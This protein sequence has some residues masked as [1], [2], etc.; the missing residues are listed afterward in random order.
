MITVEHLLCSNAR[1]HVALGEG[2]ALLPQ[3]CLTACLGMLWGSTG[4]DHSITQACAFTYAC[5]VGS[6]SPS[7]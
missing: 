2:H 4:N 7:D 5:P 1:G 3:H 6:P